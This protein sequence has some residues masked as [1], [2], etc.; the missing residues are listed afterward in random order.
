MLT[1]IT[2]PIVCNYD[3]KEEQHPE[4]VTFFTI[5]A[6][7]RLATKQTNSV[8]YSGGQTF[9]CTLTYSELW[10]RLN[11]IYLQRI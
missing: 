10:D 7:A 4:T 2:L 8:I 11:A 9:H 5:D 6:I 3:A 1:N